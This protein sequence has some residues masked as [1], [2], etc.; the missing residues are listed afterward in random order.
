MRYVQVVIEWETLH[1]LCTEGLTH[2]FCT[3]GVPIDAKIVKVI[4]N[5]KRQC[6]QVILSHS[7][8]PKVKSSEGIPVFNIQYHAARSDA[9]HCVN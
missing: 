6:I 5:S 2:Y 8:F 9:Y 7:A 3:N 4:S 1:V